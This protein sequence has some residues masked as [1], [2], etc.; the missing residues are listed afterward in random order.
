MNRSIAFF[1]VVILFPWGT[2]VRV[3]RWAEWPGC[4]VQLFSQFA[5][6]VLLRLCGKPS[7]M[8]FPE[9]DLTTE[10]QRHREGKQRSVA[11]EG[12]PA[13]FERWPT[14]VPSLEIM[15]GRR[16]EAPLVSPYNLSR[17]K[18]ALA[19]RVS[20]AALFLKLIRFTTH[21]HRCRLQL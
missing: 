7:S 8:T 1:N 19:P 5:F 16:G 9:E 18:K 2:H 11:E 21:D 14:L 6:C 20:W 17:F 3:E 10:A 15:V 12:G 4:L 13:L